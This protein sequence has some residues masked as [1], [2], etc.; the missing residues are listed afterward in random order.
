MERT[1]AL[2]MHEVAFGNDKIEV[3]EQGNEFLVTMKPLCERIGLDWEAQRQ[4]I[5]RDPVL[6]SVT[7]IIQATAKDGKNYE[8]TCLPLQYL[9]GW[10]FRVNSARYEGELKEK[11]IRYQKECYQVLFER[12]SASGLIIRMLTNL[13]GAQKR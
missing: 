12:F 7:C 11:L 1:T 5:D 6:N 10:L 8:T 9:N 4:L 2:T 3:I 13:N